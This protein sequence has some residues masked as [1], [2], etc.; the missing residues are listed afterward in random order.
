MNAINSE[1]C[2][3]IYHMR[4]IN[5]AM[6]YAPTSMECVVM[7]TERSDDTSDMT[8]HMCRR[9]SGSIPELGCG[10]DDYFQSA[11]MIQLK[12]MRALSYHGC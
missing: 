5:G 7:M 10:G 3:Y 4:L 2:M 8:S 9:L 11:V 6:R 12:Y 1:T